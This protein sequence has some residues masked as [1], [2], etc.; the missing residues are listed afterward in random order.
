MIIGKI[1][2]SAQRWPWQA[3]YDWKGMK[4]RGAP[5]N[6]SGARF[7][8]G[9]RYALGIEWGETTVILNLLYGMIRISKVRP[10]P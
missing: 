1:E 5:L 7:G 2:I 6:A 4:Y 10:K 3:G 8:G 9:W